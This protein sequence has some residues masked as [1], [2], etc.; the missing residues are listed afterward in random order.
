MKKGYSKTQGFIFT[1][2]I[3]ANILNFGQLLREKRKNLYFFKNCW[4]VPK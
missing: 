3:L 4:C 1:N 2:G